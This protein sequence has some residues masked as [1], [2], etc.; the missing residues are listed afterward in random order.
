MGLIGWL[1]DGKQE[2]DLALKGR[3][4][5]KAIR[6]DMA[7]KH[8]WGKTLAA[9]AKDFAITSVAA[10][11]AFFA[12]PENLGAI[13][14]SLSPEAR[15]ALIPFVS[16]LLVMARKYIKHSAPPSAGSDLKAGALVGVLCLLSLSSPAAAQDAK[17]PSGTSSP[18]SWFTLSS[19][20]TRFFTPGIGDITEIEG[21]V[22]LQVEAPN[23]VTVEGFARFTRTQGAEP[24]TSGLLDIKTFRSIVG[25]LAVHRPIG[26]PSFMGGQLPFFGAGCSAGL[27]WERDK[28][29]DP[30][31]PNIWAVGC[32]P[33]VQ[34]PRGSL[35]LK[36]GHNGSVGGFAAFGELV[37]NQGPRVRYVATYAIPFD[38]AR[39]RQN[40]G[41]FTGGLQIDVFS[42]AF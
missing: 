38:A 4:A 42:K 34:V 6:K 11:V 20:A 21:Q 41:T 3:R 33:R 8:D 29:F 28:T 16:G 18:N 24:G 35:T 39:F 22:L 13:L 40:P 31:D 19:G 2:L 17:E 32:G 25:H 9:V 27:S 10:L 1:K 12:I 15:A 7:M 26:G 5:V 36:V 14:G 30:S 23:L 37:I